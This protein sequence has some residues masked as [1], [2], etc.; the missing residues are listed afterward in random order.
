MARPDY[1]VTLLHR[2]L[3]LMV[4]AAPICGT[5]AFM[6]D[7]VDVARKFIL[8]SFAAFL[9]GGRRLLFKQRRVDLEGIL[10]R[11]KLSEIKV[12]PL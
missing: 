3:Q 1:N 10:G 12:L 2:A 8:A 4:D 5:A 6:Y 9:G 7:L 11:S